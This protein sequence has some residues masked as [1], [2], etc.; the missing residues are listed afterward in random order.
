M[1]PFEIVE[2][3]QWSVWKYKPQNSQ[4]FKPFRLQS[5]PHKCTLH[6]SVRKTTGG[7]SLCSLLRFLSSNI[8]ST[9]P[10]PVKQLIAKWQVFLYHAVYNVSHSLLSCK[11]YV[12]LCITA[13]L[14][15]INASSLWCLWGFLILLFNMKF[16][17]SNCWCDAW[18]SLWCS[19]HSSPYPAV[20]YGSLH[21]TSALPLQISPPSKS[22]TPSTSD[23]ASAE[24]ME[25]ALSDLAKEE[26]FGGM[27]EE[28]GSCAPGKAAGQMKG[29]REKIIV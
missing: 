2:V 17:Y 12:W 22:N 24:N 14:K 29:V 3:Q 28:C 1:K 19:L 7:L 8:S 9:T 11:V 6:S 27:C 18:H 13:L 20:I 25:S 10:Q 26:V 21:S 4:P 15:A 16:K 23:G 5:V